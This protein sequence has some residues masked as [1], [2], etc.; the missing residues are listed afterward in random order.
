V[1]GSVT[2][3]GSSWS[4]VVDRGIDP[5]TGRRR[6][7]RRSG[8]RTRREAEEAVRKTIAAL[9]DGT[10]VERTDQTLDEYLNSWLESLVSG[11]RVKAKTAHTYEECLRRVRPMIG[12]VRLQ[13]LRALDI[14]RAYTTLLQSGR[15]DGTGLHPRSVLHT[16][17]VLH[18][19]L[20]DA[21]RL[22]LVARNVAKN[23]ALP[24][25]P[26]L[27]SVDNVWT[28]EQL[29]SFLEGAAAE[30]LYAAFVLAAT[31]GM[32][33]GEVAALRWQDLDLD[34]AVL[35][36]E[37]SVT[38]VRG[39]LVFSAPKTKKG[40]RQVS[41][42]G[43]TVAV[44]RAH[45]VRQSERRL[46]LGPAWAET[47]RVFTREDGSHLHPDVLSKRFD[48]WIRRIGLPHISFHGLRHTWA[49]MALEKGIH[50]KVV[51]ERLGHANVA[52]TLDI[53]SKVRP[54]LDLEAAERVAGELFAR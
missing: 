50:T 42:D 46:A 24:A 33:R 23:V 17:R 4:F 18:K 25:M 31:T 47:G 35:R 19:A 8:F 48:A 9:V 20:A 38:P 10:F 21:E 49:T 44:L 15:R 52:V 26:A 16:H 29:R 2:K 39:A 7:Q 36:V 53:Y 41:L 27:T 22:G 6:Q 34:A 43:A 1:R 28:T 13:A 11:Q 32:R 37:E 12:P 54:A 5:A 3:R 51:S 40:V 45:R 14:E 30:P